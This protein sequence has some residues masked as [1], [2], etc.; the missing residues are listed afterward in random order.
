[1]LRAAQKRRVLPSRTLPDPRM[2]SPNQ[3]N[4]QQRK[5]AQTR[6]S[7]GNPQH[8]I[9]VSQTKY[10]T[11]HSPTVIPSPNGGIVAFPQDGLEQFVP[12]FEL[13]PDQELP[14]WLSESNLGDLALSQYGLEAFLIPQQFDNQQPLPAEIW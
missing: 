1:M 7:M 6:Q 4:D 11:M 3:A 2:I 12:G 14:V 13:N 8:V 5:D 9:P 10:T